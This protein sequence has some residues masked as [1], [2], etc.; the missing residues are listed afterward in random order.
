[1]LR[2]QSL[3]SVAMAVTGVSGDPGDS[4]LNFSPVAP[5]LL[6]PAATTT[7]G[8]LSFDTRL[9]PPEDNYLATTHNVTGTQHISMF[10]CF[11]LWQLKALCIC[12]Y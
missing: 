5:P 10:T 7:L 3:F 2:V 6:P 9:L 1:M 11:G 12:A 4:R 8:T